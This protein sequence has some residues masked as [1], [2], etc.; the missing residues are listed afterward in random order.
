LQE[1][2]DQLKSLRIDRDPEPRRASK[3]IAILVLLVV[4]GAGGFYYVRNRGS[5]GA[6]EVQAAQ[7]SVMQRGGADP[8]TP[9]LTASGYVVARRKAV[10]SAKIQGR[11]S[12]LRVEEGSHVKEGEVIARLESTDYL[13]QIERS[14]AAIV[15]AEADLHEAKRQAGIADKLANAQ[16]QSIDQRDAANSRVQ[17][18]EAALV[19][20]KADLGVQDALY[21]NTFIRAPFTGVVVKK[22]A[23][24]GESVAPIP[25]GVN[26]STASGAIVALA[27]LATLEVEADVNEANVAQLANNQPAE[28]VVQAFPSKTYH[29]TLRQ[30]IPTADRTKATVMVKVTILDK[31]KD[32]KPEMSA[33]VTFLEAPKK[34]AAKNTAPERII[35]VPKNAIAKRENRTVVFEI[36][37]GKAA[38]RPVV[39]GS[40]MQDRIVVKQ[41]LVGSETLV[42]SPPDSLHDG[43]NVKTKG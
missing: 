7:A 18:A 12:E 26:I 15:R 9:I 4:L 28:V 11:L 10:V 3:W 23:E 14:K 35:T 39:T 41:G 40:E 6:I 13:A 24:V 34:G 21:Q 17:L 29:A 32:L 5:L 16:V 1:L 22:M 42:A 2:R 37:N 19:Q 20:A 30:V 27:D 38:E 33:N 36:E 25:P 43:D 8:G 31:D